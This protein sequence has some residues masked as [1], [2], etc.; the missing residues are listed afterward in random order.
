MRS[1]SKANG[2][3]TSLNGHRG[4]I[5]HD[6]EVFEVSNA[7]LGESSLEKKLP[8]SHIQA[9]EKM[10]CLVCNGLF[11]KWEGIWR[12]ILQRNF[13]LGTI[14]VH[15]LHYQGGWWKSIHVQQTSSWEGAIMSLEDIIRKRVILMSQR[16][17]LDPVRWNYFETSQKYYTYKS[18]AKK[19]DCTISA[20]T[21]AL[22]NRSW[23]FGVPQTEQANNVL[24][25]WKR[26]IFG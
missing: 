19:T 17:G 24:V 6:K 26:W 18:N 12:W 5:K 8:W 1:R 16:N 21:A 2:V 23:G 3:V 14:S 7:F 4:Q 15:C 20:E 9:V 22:K 10:Y 11:S 25:F 13:F